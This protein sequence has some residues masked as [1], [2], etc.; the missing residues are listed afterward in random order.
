MTC[1]ECADALVL[2]AEREAGLTLRGEERRDADAAAV[3]VQLCSACR[4]E[5]DLVRETAALFAALP[6]PEPSAA[7]DAR[8]LAAF[9]AEQASVAVPAEAAEALPSFRRLPRWVRRVA[10]GYAAGW[11]TLAAA[12]GVWM[13]AGGWHTVVEALASVTGPALSGVATAT[14]HGVEFVASLV[15]A[16]RLA[17]QVMQVVA[18]AMLAV[19]RALQPSPMM[20]VLL[21]TLAGAAGVLALLTQLPRVTRRRTRHV[22][23]I[24]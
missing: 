23:A 24:L 5:F 22:H 3:H 8:V 1:T 7:F 15:V 4:T 12:T 19:G 2:L 11:G 10:V 17:D 9:F 6:S 18:P 20:T 16:L 14:Q 13:L 21:V